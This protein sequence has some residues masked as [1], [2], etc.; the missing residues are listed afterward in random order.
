M[1]DYLYDWLLCVSFSVSQ[2][3]CPT[4]PLTFNLPIF[5]LFLS[6]VLYS[7]T[8][9]ASHFSAFVSSCLSISLSVSLLFSFSS[10]VVSV[11]L[12]LSL[13]Y[14]S[15]S[16]CLC[17]S[18]PLLSASVFLPSATSYLCFCV[19]FLFLFVSSVNLSLC[20]SISKLYLA[21]IPREDSINLFSTIIAWP[22]PK[23]FSPTPIFSSPK[24]QFYCTG[25][26][27]LWVTKSSRI[28]FKSDFLCLLP[29]AEY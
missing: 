6:I 21:L 27:K 10:L 17:L 25:S 18:M 7:C 2:T 5:Y 9:V 20:L 22:Q 1:F 29:L 28:P 11:P 8:S 4:V 13:S 3:L 23:Y 26:G 15:L 24:K 16:L 14:L 19:F 12:S